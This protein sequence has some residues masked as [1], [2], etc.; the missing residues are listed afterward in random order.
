MAG[1]GSTPGASPPA[2]IGEVIAAMQ[3]IDS[4]L[5]R[6]DG[7]AVFN[8]LYLQVTKAVLAAGARTA[9]HDPS[10]LDRLDVV[11]AGFYFD[12]EATIAGGARCPVAWRP[13]VQERGRPHAPIQFA[14]AGMNAHINHDLPLA[15]VQ[16]CQELGIAPADDTPQHSD[17]EAVN[18]ILKQVEG[19]VVVWFDT[20]LIADLEDVVPQDVDNALA[21][22]SIAAARELAWDHAK[23]IWSLRQLATTAAEAYEDVLARETELSGRAMLV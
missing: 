5:P 8:R 4:T 6:N 14:L 13:L 17:Y 11:F 22:W 21:M 23:L 20:G 2:T 7:V 9:F 18:A 19:R 10:F 3:R 16:T 15:I 12:A 1:R